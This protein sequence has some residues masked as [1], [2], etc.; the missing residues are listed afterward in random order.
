MRKWGI[1]ITAFYTLLLVFLILPGV[2]LLIGE[3]FPGPLEVA[4]AMVD[5]NV[6]AEVRLSFWVI[7]L[8]LAAA[9]ALLLFVSVDTSHRKLRP[10]AR[11]GISVAVIAT[12][13]GL[14]MTAALWAVAVALLGED[15]P[16]LDLTIWLL[17]LTGSWL[18]WGIVFYVY[19]DQL[20]NRLDRAVN[21]LIA[22]SV[23]ELL[24]V[25]PCHVIVRHRGDCSAPVA[26]GLGIA[27]G[28]AIMLMAFGP[29]VVFLY[30]K[31]MRQ[32]RSGDSP[33]LPG[34]DGESA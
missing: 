33:S 32:Y 24:I 12:A 31:R 1:L 22:G 10:R 25:V 2:S 20:W 23:L 16:A 15:D 29:S 6:A 8:M 30:Q 17:I 11:I 19:R 14:L 18:A 9:Q 21:W 27:T 5:P 26:T 28:I 3:E 4:R 13:V 7:V 34:N